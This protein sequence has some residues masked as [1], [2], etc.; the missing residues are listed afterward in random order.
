[1][2]GLLVSRDTFVPTK[3]VLEPD[4]AEKSYR[5]EMG[6]KIHCELAIVHFL[7]MMEKWPFWGI[8]QTINTIIG[9]TLWG[10]GR[11][12]ANAAKTTKEPKLQNPNLAAFNG[13]FTN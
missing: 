1:M 13:T 5:T 2:S 7:E 6:Q 3:I 11:G 4:L 8:V 12:L 10:P 9:F